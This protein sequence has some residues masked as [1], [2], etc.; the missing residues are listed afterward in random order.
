MDDLIRKLRTVFVNEGVEENGH[1]L[2]YNLKILQ[3]ALL[4]HKELESTAR[5]HTP[6]TDDEEPPPGEADMALATSRS[7]PDENFSAQYWN[8][9]K[10]IEKEEAKEVGSP[11]SVVVVEPQ[12]NS[13][14]GVD[15]AEDEE[16]VYNQFI[17][18]SV[19]HGKEGYKKWHNQHV[20]PI[21]NPPAAPPTATTKT[22]KDLV[23]AATAKPIEAVTDPPELTKTQI[24]LRGLVKTMVAE[25][26]F[27]SKAVVAKLFAGCPV[28]DIPDIPSDLAPPKSDPQDSAPTKEDPNNPSTENP[29]NIPDLSELSKSDRTSNA[30]E[31]LANHPSLKSWIANREKAYVIAAKREEVHVAKL[32]NRIADLEAELDITKKDF[33]SIKRA[34]ELTESEQL[35]QLMKLQKDHAAME[36][37][38]EETHKEI[39]RLNDLVMIKEQSLDD[40]KENERTVTDNVKTLWGKVKTLEAKYQQELSKLSALNEKKAFGGGHLIDSSVLS[41][42]GMKDEKGCQTDPPPPPPPSTTTP[43]SLPL[44][45]PK[46]RSSRVGRKSSF[47]HS[48]INLPPTSPTGHR[49][50]FDTMQEQQPQQLRR[51]SSMFANSKVEL[52]LP[53]IAGGSG[54]PKTS[55]GASA[56]DDHP[57]CGG[58]DPSNSKGN[59]HPKTTT[60]SKRTPKNNLSTPKQP[61]LA[62]GGGRRFSHDT[63]AHRRMSELDTYFSKLCMAT[64]RSY[65]ALVNPMSDDYELA[66]TLFEQ[67]PKEGGIVEVIRQF[68]ITWAAQRKSMGS[69][70]SQAHNQTVSKLKQE[71]EQLKAAIQATKLADKEEN[72]AKDELIKL[73]AEN[74][75]LHIAMGYYNRPKEQMLEKI[76]EL[77]MVLHDLR[78]KNVVL[79]ESNRKLSQRRRHQRKSSRS[80][81]GRESLGDTMKQ[82]QLGGS[83]DE[84]GSPRGVASP[85]TSPRNADSHVVHP[86][87]FPI[88][89]I[90]PVPP[91][92]PRPGDIVSTRS[93]RPGHGGLQLEGIEHAF[94]IRK[95]PRTGL[96]V[97]IPDFPAFAY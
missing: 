84:Q 24:K 19:A 48:N 15:A 79:S 17:S 77:E 47:S 37:K 76:Q 12:S 61:P 29:A 59:I 46:G 28:E 5:P 78:R 49:K 82:T 71:V 50:N 38:I 33:K 54:N 20:E 18:E 52:C 8:N 9:I 43:P 58:S 75:K 42:Y 39:R 62:G 86:T 63:F 81:D 51:S 27:L 91:T 96:L 7:D 21:L 88:V 65:K 44:D 69:R 60:E 6:S 30:M 92:S 97:R 95:S 55:T 2:D 35:F 25:K 56:A 45:S 73:K 93:N 89:R 64:I 90:S 31:E 13:N 68:E 74:K 87:V 14:N 83:D 57:F 85:I 3:K 70:E 1:N 66:H 22:F 23:H 40:L 36:Y 41:A 4:R 72:R 34:V 16:A 67:I 32:R 53:N 80:S 94:P 26:R 11:R 10:R